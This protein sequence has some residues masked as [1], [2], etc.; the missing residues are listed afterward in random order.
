M[1]VRSLISGMQSFELDASRQSGRARFF[2][3]MRTMT[4]S[5]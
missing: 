3:A 1:Q 5:Q 4:P 2:R